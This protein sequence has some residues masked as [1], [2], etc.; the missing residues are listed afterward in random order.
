MNWD[1]LISFKKIRCNALS[2]SITSSWSLN[3]R[4]FLCATEIA[5]AIREEFL[6]SLSDNDTITGIENMACYKVYDISGVSMRAYDCR[7]AYA[8][9]VA[10][11]ISMFNVNGFSN[12]SLSDTVPLSSS[13]N[14]LLWILYIGLPFMCIIILLILVVYR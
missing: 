3:F 2:Y 14:D 12:E 1:A 5:G 8:D 4:S 6:A 7:P 10:F 13:N 11:K 9:D